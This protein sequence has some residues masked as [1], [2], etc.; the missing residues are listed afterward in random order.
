MW[1]ESVQKR[2][3]GAKVTNADRIRAMTDEELAS[4]FEGWV[5]DCGCN[6]VPCQETCTLFDGKT[7]LERWL[8][9]L[10]QEVPE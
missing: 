1:L 3:E 8:E 4:L 6:A 2:R 5:Q 10:K 9:W 7:C